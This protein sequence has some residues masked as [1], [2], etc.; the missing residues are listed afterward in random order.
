MQV[1]DTITNALCEAWSVI[2]QTDEEYQVV[3]GSEEEVLLYRFCSVLLYISPL[4]TFSVV[5]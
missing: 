4:L 2:S 5:D 3:L 1:L